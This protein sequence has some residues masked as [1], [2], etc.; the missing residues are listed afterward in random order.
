MDKED[1]VCICNG[2]L[3]SQKKEQNC[4]ICR[5]AVGPRDSYRVKKVQKRKKKSYNNF[6]MWN[7]E[8]DV[9][10]FI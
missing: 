3:L 6:Y 9:G 10:E 5:D 8:N 4:A 7:V 1:V 2:T